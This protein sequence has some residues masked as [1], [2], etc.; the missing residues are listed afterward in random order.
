[1]MCRLRVRQDVVIELAARAAP[2]ESGLVA[3]VV[4]QR[5]STLW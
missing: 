1:M 4:S 3:D 2:Q 5:R